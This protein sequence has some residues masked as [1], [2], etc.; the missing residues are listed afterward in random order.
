MAHTY[1][2]PLVD[3]RETR[4]ERTART[5]TFGPGMVLGLLGTA[6]LVISMFL[7]WH[8]NDVHPSGIPLA[9]LFDNGTT[10]ED[11]SI[12]LALIP[13]A[14]LLGLGSVM[15]RASAARVIGSL[16]ALAV[17]VLFGI[18]LNQQLDKVPGASLGDVLET[19]FYVGA[20]AALVGLVSAFMPAVRSRSQLVKT[21][22][23]VDDRGAA[24]D[25]RRI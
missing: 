1:Q 19:G 3:P 5:A 2:D 9:F 6:G 22:A 21:Q 4:S 16:G 12:L 17:V 14:A 13:F 8:T 25:E 10:A 18:Q 15:P 24:Y 11:P 20:I 23:V 7:A